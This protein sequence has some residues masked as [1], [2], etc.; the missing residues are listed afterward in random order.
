MEA[1]QH[2]LEEGQPERPEDRGAFF[3]VRSMLLA[4][5]AVASAAL[6]REESRGAHFRDDFP[7]TKDVWAKSV[8]TRLD[9]AN[10]RSS[11]VA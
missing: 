1:W 8:Y 7:D 9:G 6:L 11:V 5:R 10:I 4:S 3:E 2:S